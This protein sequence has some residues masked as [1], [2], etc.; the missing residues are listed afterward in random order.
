MAE[1][2]ARWSIPL[3]YPSPPLSLNKG[4]GHWAKT[5]GIKATLRRDAARLARSAKIGHHAHIHT[6]LHWTPPDNRRRDEDNIIL[7]AKPLWDGLVDAGVVV[8]DTSTYMTKLMPRIH[9]GKKN[10]NGE[11]RL[12]LDVWTTEDTEEP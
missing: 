11:P 7:T 10:M 5:S 3:P 4:Q 6:R 9:P 8:D 12:W 1:I 2:T